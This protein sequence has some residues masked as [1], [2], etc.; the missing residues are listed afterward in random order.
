MRPSQQATRENP[1]KQ[2]KRGKWGGSSGLDRNI[3]LNKTI[4]S[5]TI[6]QW[7][8][9]MKGFPTLETGED[10]SDVVGELKGTPNE[11]KRGRRIQLPFK[12]DLL[13]AIE[14]RLW[15]EQ[16]DAVRKKDQGL[17]WESF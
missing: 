5:R 14:R 9:G 2:P 4:S 7:E 15:Q 8:R 17:F 16:S 13:R 6:G 10:R 11:D 1:S 12:A 3:P